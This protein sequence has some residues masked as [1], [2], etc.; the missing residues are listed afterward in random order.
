MDS[1]R[2][3][4]FAESLEDYANFPKTREWIDQAIAGILSR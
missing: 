2:W 1:I 4:V 3:E